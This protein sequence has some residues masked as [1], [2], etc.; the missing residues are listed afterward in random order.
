MNASNDEIRE[1]VRAK[2]AALA[3]GNTSGCGTAC[4]DSDSDI[5]NMIGDAYDTV[6][7]YVADADLQLGCG[8]P[9]EHAG[10]ESGQTVVDLGSGAGLDAFVARR[11]VGDTGQ[12]IGVDFAPEMVAKA[13][14]NAEQLGFDNVSFIEGDIE[15]IPLEANTADVVLSNCVLNLVPDKARAF[16][17]MHRILKPGGHF[18][19]SDIVSE[20]TLPDPIQRSAELYA[21]CVAGALDEADYLAHIRAAGFENVEIHT[22]RGIEI[23]DEVFP[24]DL[25]ETDRD[26][27]AK[28]GLFSIT[29]QGT[30]SPS[31]P[32]IQEQ[33]DMPELNVYDPP[34]CCSTGVC[35]PE[36]DD[37]LVNFSSALRWLRRHGVAVTRYNPSTTPEAFMDTQIVYDALMSEGQDVL[38]LL[39]L[40][41]EIVHKGDYPSKEALTQLVGLTPA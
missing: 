6:E 30:K 25:S 36:T 29:V 13:T 39:I 10:L 23:P 11:I 4:C 40:D 15:D 37:T 20:G 33:P 9:T 16:A 21:G 19:V 12:V 32:R 8:V 7:G 26:A 41:G 27:C 5:T 18:T 14:A 3:Q 31:T 38:P 24:N 35:G 17:E 34:M 22:R 2:Y 1:A 28:S